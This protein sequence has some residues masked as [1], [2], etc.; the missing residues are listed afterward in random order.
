MANDVKIRFKNFLPGSG[1]NSAGDP[2]QGKTRV[3]GEV[4][5]TS[6]QSGEPLSAIDIGLTT[7]DAINLRVS[8]AS[9]EASAENHR[10][11]IY[12]KSQ[13]QFYLVNVQV[14]GTRAEYAAAA[15]E[16]LEFDAFGDSAD[17]VEL[18]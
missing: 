18:T 12:V 7:I 5:V 13:A 11:V 6:Y 4:D 8:D 1:R 14:A 15:T 17:D 2:K 10:D 3:V 16:T 9:G